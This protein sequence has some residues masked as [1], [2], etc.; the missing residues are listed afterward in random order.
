MTS[1][2]KILV[3]VSAASVS[4]FFSFSNDSMDAIIFCKDTLSVGLLSGSRALALL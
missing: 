4:E 2:V 3:S 1:L